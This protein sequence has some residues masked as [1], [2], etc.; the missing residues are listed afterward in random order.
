M[1]ELL[2]T[3]VSLSTQKR[4][5]LAALLKKQG[6]NLYGVTPIFP[7]D[8]EEPVPLS[9]AQQRL[10]ILSQLGQVGS[11]YN[12]SSVLRF[13]GQLDTQALQRSFEA[14]IQRHETLRTTF[15]LEGERAVQVIHPHTPFE[16]TLEA[17]EG[18][19]DSLL[20]QRVEAQ[21][22]LPFDLR[23]GPLL[24]GRLLRLA[25]EE[26]VLVLTLHHIVS[27]GWSMPVMVNELVQLYHG[28]SQGQPVDLPALSVQYAD[29]AIWQRNWM[30]AGEQEKQLAYWTAQ[31]G[32]EQ[33]V[34]ELPCDRPR[35]A[36]SSHQG[37]RVTVALD[38]DLAGAL[39]RL[40]QLQG[41][42]PF[43]LLLASF[44]ALLHRYSGQ[45]DIRVGVPVANRNRAET[46]RLIGFFVNTQV[47]RAEFDLQMTFSQ[48]LQQVKQRAVDAQAHQDLPF[49]QLVEALQVER[50]PG[51]SP[52]FQVMYNHQTQAKGARSSLQGLEMEELA[53]DSHSAKFDLTLDTFEHEQGIGAALTYATDLFDA[54]TIE[55]M[56]RHWLSLL[57]GIVRDPAQRVADL[58][59]LA[60]PEH[61]LIVR[62]WNATQAE[63]PHERSIH[64]LIEAQVLAT[65]DA[66][67]L[68]FGE[69]TLSYAELNRRANQLAHK[70]REQGVGPDVLVGIAMQR[71]LEM[72]IGLLGIV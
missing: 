15:E 18:A 37:A 35:P 11:A 65:P 53:W 51:H 4:K 16:L 25:A 46:E 57:Q 6:V 19:D 49:E 26:H 36:V 50:N 29:Y 27:D 62:D 59:L 60:E 10:W 32:D 34:L 17:L 7:R 71:S 67:A 30:E 23:H 14:L 40:A 70:L 43:M 63:Y 8:P 68:V 47:L 9:Y 2:D 13:R 24:R 72:V 22:H 20:R 3:V 48:L 69:Q 66:P 38:N 45:P 55:S 33:P 64:Q 41:V 56:A 28:V 12:L 39:K 61:H 1:Q 21:A 31:L 42:T 54:T 44:Q 58:P 52:L 5:A